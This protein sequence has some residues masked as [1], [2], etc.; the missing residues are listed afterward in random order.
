[1]TRGNR[2]GFTLVELLVVITIIS[3]LASMLLP[4]LVRARVAARSAQC[5][6][7]LRQIGMA[8]QMFMTDHK[9]Y[10]PPVCD[11]AFLRF[12]W[13]QRT[14]YGPDDPV[15]HS[16]GY[17]SQYIPGGEVGVCPQ[18]ALSRME[19]VA[20]GATAGYAY[21]SYYIG[22]NGNAIAPDWS[23][24]P[25][26]PA[27]GGEVPSPSRTIMFT[28]SVTVDNVFAPSR[29]RENWLLDPPS[30]N[31]HPP[32]PYTTQA[33][34]HFRHGGMANVLFCDGH[35]ESMQPHELWDVLDGTLGWLGPDDEMFD[36]K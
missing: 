24:W 28:D 1:M 8:V 30:M 35:V 15:D 33:L 25:G 13:G 10:Y 34:V 5:K 2:R 26:M 17:I 32:A 14:G 27:R 29:Y 31:Y 6:S 21:N 23:N 22:G 11:N 16:K 19:L 4:A 12:W 9:E 7:N 36:R 3:I 18:M 20:A